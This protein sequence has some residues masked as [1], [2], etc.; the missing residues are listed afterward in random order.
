MTKQA[1]MVWG[2]WEGHLPRETVEVFRPWLESQ[3]YDVALEDCLEVYGD[4]ERLKS[5]ALIVQCW[6]L[7]K[8]EPE[9][10]D[11][12]LEAVAS[13]VG[14]AGW[15]GGIVDSFRESSDYQWMTGGQFVCHPGELVPSY[16]VEVVDPDH[17]ITKGLG[18]FEL[19]GTEQYYCQ[20]DPSNH[21]LCTTAFDGGHGDPMKYRVGTVLP[22]AWTR[23]WG[24]G[25]VFVAC[26]GH[27]PA[28]FEPPAAREIVQR[29]L[30]WAS[31]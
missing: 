26:W 31:R 16:R 19:K 17:P 29:G 7:G 20:V 27:S 30:V 1:L 24:E 28:D 10:Q 18:A 4:L 3:G 6:T 21:V 25:R 9:Q 14:F 13:G 22:Y 5:F 15:H 2:G 12:L 8:L 23:T 11:A